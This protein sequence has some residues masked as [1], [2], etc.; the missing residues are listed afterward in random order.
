[1]KIKIILNDYHNPGQKSLGHQAQTF[2]ESSY[3]T[4]I[5]IA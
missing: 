3:C 4:V 1:M 2:D 5:S